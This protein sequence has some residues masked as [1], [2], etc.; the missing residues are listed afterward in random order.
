MDDSLSQALA[1]AYAS[2]PADDPI[3][4]TLEIR[5]PAFVDDLG[6]NIALRIIANNEDFEGRLEDDAP[7]NAGELVTFTSL[8]FD[9]Q[10]PEV[11]TSTVPE[12]NVTIDN[13][14]REIMPHLKAAAT[15]NEKIE[16]TY[17]PYLASDPNTV[18]MDPPL[19]LTLK[20][21][22]ATPVSITGVASMLDIGNKAFP[23]DVYTTK[24]FPGLAQ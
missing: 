14:S 23:S 21:V 18:Q 5:H 22:S 19:T 1:E 17:R 4:D 16:I 8:G 2:C 9:I 20:S 7:M 3:L 24:R 10:L 15:S 11:A 12:V 13:V 6:N